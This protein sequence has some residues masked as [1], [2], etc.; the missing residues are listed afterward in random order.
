MGTENTESRTE[1]ESSTLQRSILID[2][3]T[4]RLSLIHIMD[5]FSSLVFLLN[6]RNPLDILSDSQF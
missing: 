5:V 2:R 4:K 6:E 3:K 1:K